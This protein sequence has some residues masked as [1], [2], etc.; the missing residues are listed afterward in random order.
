MWRVRHIST[1]AIADAATKL[2]DSITGQDV[3]AV[4]RSVA[5]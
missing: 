1:R 4:R 5:Q 3:R 2:V